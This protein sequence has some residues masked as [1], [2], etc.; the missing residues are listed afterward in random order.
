VRNHGRLLGKVALV[1]G[2]ER[3]IGKA[4]VEGLAREGASVVINYVTRADQA[5][6]VVERI[7]R[8]GGQAMA[9]YGDVSRQSD[10][11][12]VV[13]HAVKR[14]GTVDVLINNAA[15]TNVHKPWHAITE[16]E[17]DRVLAVNLKGCFLCARAAY[18]HMKKDG[19]GRIVNI[20]SVTVALGQ[21]NL[22]H[23]V[24]SKAGIIGFTR[25][26]ARELGSD[27]ITVNAIAPGAIRTEA[28]LE[29]FPDQGQIEVRQ[30]DVQA[31]KRR[32]LPEDIAGAVVFLASD[33]SSFV[34]GQ[35]LFVD[36]GWVMH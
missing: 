6:E 21:A 29:M 2:G 32:G 25:G 31:L 4:I 22:L 13:H 14:F 5:L 36:G 9:V 33:E 20:S 11:S 17:W 3:G 30:N 23:Y 10:V 19:S 12:N 7:E 8:T 1:T 18:P 15:I 35:T 27:Q 24:S 26:L 28:E 16:T 34:T